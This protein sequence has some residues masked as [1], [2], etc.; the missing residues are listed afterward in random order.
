MIRDYQDIGT[1]WGNIRVILGFYG[2]NGKE[3]GNYY[4]RKWVYNGAKADK[5]LAAGRRGSRDK[6][7][8][9]THRSPPEA[10]ALNLQAY[11]SYTLSSLKWGYIVGEYSRAYQGRYWEF[12]P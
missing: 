5:G 10:L 7:Q 12:R 4:M 2:D 3:N 11:M 9:N 1:H 8:F 6:L